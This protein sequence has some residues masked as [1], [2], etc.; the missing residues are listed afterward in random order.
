MVDRVLSLKACFGPV[1]IVFLHPNVSF[2]GCV[3]SESATAL[4][5]LTMHAAVAC[6]KRPPHAEEKVDA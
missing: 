1:T 6:C 4:V 3:G 5:V 2:F